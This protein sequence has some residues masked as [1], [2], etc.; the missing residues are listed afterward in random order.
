MQSAPPESLPP[1]SDE[2]WL[3]H[4]TLDWR[5]PGDL[6]AALGR[7]AET[8]K[9]AFA[10]DLCV[11]FAINPVTRR[12]LPN[13]GVAGDLWPDQ[14]EERSVK[15]PRRH[16]LTRR[17]LQEGSLVVGDVTT[18]SEDD[19]GFCRQQGVCC[20][21]SVALHTRPH[22][23]PFAVLYVDYRRQRALDG[24]LEEQLQRFARVASRELQTTWFLRR[25]RLV[26]QIGQRINQRPQTE[27][28]LFQALWS[29]VGRIIDTSHCFL[30]GIHRLQNNTLDLFGRIEGRELV[31]QSRAVDGPLMWL[32]QNPGVQIKAL[33]DETA[34]MLQKVARLPGNLPWEPQSLL[35]VPLLMEGRS[36][37]VLSVQHPEPNAFDEEDRYLLELLATHV[38]LALSNLWLYGHLRRLHEA[39]QTLTRNLESETVLQAVVDAI[40]ETT[41]CDIAVLYP[42]N[43]ASD[44]FELPPHWSG[45]LLDPSLPQPRYAGQSAVARFILQQPEPL[46]E[47]DA[48]QLIAKM[49]EHPSQ[50]KGGFQKREKI[51][52]VAAL[53]LQVGE[54][55]VGALFVNYRTRQH[56]PRDAAQQ[57]L[58]QGLA[59][60]AAIAIKNARVLGAEQSRYV[61]NLEALRDFDRAL[62]R[63]ND[64]K[65][66]LETILHLAHDRLADRVAPDEAS[67]LLYD[68][69][70]HALVPGAAIGAHPEEI[71]KR[72]FR[73]GEDH[74]L[75]LE[76]F[77]GQTILAPDVD[78]AEWQGRYLDLEAGTRCELDV[79]LLDGDTVVGILNLESRTP[80]AFDQADVQLM[81][82]LAGQAVL[83]VKKAQEYEEKTEALHQERRL[84]EDEEA[85]I[86]LG[87]ELTRRL[88]VDG[89][90][91]LI[92]QRA[93]EKTRANAGVLALAHDS[94]GDLIVRAER[95]VP[96][97]V[98]R[99]RLSRDRGILGLV[100]REGEVINADLTDPRWQAIHVPAVP[101]MQSEIALPLRQGQQVIGVLNV[102]SPEPHFFSPRNE[103]VLS[104]LADLAVIALQNAERFE[105]ADRRQRKLKA[106]D[107]VGRKVVEQLDHPDQVMRA[108]VRHAL[109]LTR[110]SISDLDLYDTGEWITHYRARTD[111]GGAV[112]ALDPLDL[113]QPGAKRP[114]R[115]IM[116]YVA[117]TR[118]PLLVPGDAQGHP[119]YRG[120]EGIHSELAVPLLTAKGELLG[121]LDVTSAKLGAFDEEDQ[122]LLELF[123]A[124]AVI[125]IENSRSYNLSDQSR[126][127][128]ELLHQAGQELAQINDLAHLVEAYEIVVKMVEEQFESEVVVRRFD[129]VTQELVRVTSARTHGPKLFDRIGL[130]DPLNGRVAQDKM[131][132]VVDDADKPP[133]EIGP[134]RRSNTED[135]S[136]LVT[137]IQF[138]DSSYYYGNL[139]LSHTAVSHFRDADVKLIEGLAQQLAITIH[140]L[141]EV[142]AHQEAEK[143]AMEA[144]TMGEIGRQTYEIMHRLGNDL[145]LVPDSVRKIRAALDNQGIASPDVATELSNIQGDVR[146][147][148]DLS[149]KLANELSTSNELGTSRELKVYPVGELIR[150]GVGSL[151]LDE[152]K[153]DRIRIDVQPVAVDLRICVDYGELIAALLNLLSNAVEAM[154]NGGRLAVGAAGDG[155]A[156]QLWVEDTGRGIRSSDLPKLFDLGYT[157]KADS[158]GFG[159]WSVKRTIVNH[160]GKIEVASERGKGTRF[161][162][163][164]P[165]ATENAD[166]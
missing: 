42:Y 41:G 107:E 96:D 40:R 9:E 127:R 46:F 131:T 54:E 145:G 117:E 13:P 64:L 154:P 140:R 144:E 48:S 27:E 166:A 126:R 35:F 59:G 50:Q 121:V 76:A 119:H 108:I 1:P 43:Q 74:G 71:F 3:E 66:L 89:L 124:Q 7:I 5:E 106:L 148:L 18:L 132:L 37:G 88:D 151:L 120:E 146:R 122:E 150:Q 114:P 70:R 130:D 81:E 101:G 139:A 152:D 12:F 73:V 113:R 157:T 33:A 156:V 16:G 32:L 53:P 123:A 112:E 47:E 83:A 93:I 30:W 104:G 69:E 20:F 80:N 79:P 95:G 158:S 161:T 135:R 62:N 105:A 21:A 4:L 162:I 68:P 85:L 44:S 15:E 87:K 109:E 39:G 10:A 77:K 82:T 24:T 23:R 142:E 34:G 138:R 133:L 86:E 103:R 118:Q 143:R 56:L 116:H 28:R 155:D 111:P 58:I 164:L 147:V 160:G 102:E 136:F 159:L 134:F 2:H 52:S 51:R 63:S 26:G 31:E 6:D 128:F 91:D 49:G 75:T 45:E 22:G 60:Y 137:P 149:K 61:K 14:G 125:A 65:E 110:A 78:S 92:L 99:R 84:R 38:S 11:I 98:L 163:S 94:Q 141:E 153:R 90:L 115:G 55:A 8:A 129:P 36:L 67:I 165:R 97:G 29:Q 25:Y 72:T 19:S 57:Q 17:V 100:A